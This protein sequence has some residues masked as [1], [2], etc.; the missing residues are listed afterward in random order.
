MPNPALPVTDVD[1]FLWRK[2][3]DR[4][5]LF[6]MACDKLAAKKY[7][8]TVCP[9]LKT[10]EVLWTG[11]DP[12]TIPDRLLTGSV[13]VKANHASRWNIMIHNSEVD[14]EAMN[15]L[16]ASWVKRTY[17][18]AF[19]EWGYKNAAHCLLV[20]KMLLDEGRP[21]KTEYKFHVS[22]GR[23]AYVFVSVKQDGGE[24]AT[25]YFDRDGRF[26]SLPDRSDSRPLVVLPACFLRMRDIAERLAKPF[27][28]M[29]CDFYELNGDI[30]FSELTAYPL[31][32]QGGSNPKLREL[33]NT[34]WDLRKS[35]FLTK[36]QT[37][38][39]K[40][41]ARVLRE[42]LEEDAPATASDT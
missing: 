29:R 1:K 37:G 24:E 31:S 40:V 12:V 5:P 10:A 17:G 28:Y 34:G 3:F 22:G 7:A 13:V 35:W 14:R 9:E 25:C 30:F 21:I 26:S 39:R 15:N 4:N 18:R 33:R 11:R 16:A 2:I 20:E 41:Y 38:W 23:T 8:L 42:W 6:T 32:G 36:P 19:G 27:D